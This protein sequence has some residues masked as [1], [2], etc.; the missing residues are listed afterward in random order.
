MPELCD[1]S[2]LRTAWPFLK[3]P[4]FPSMGRRSTQWCWPSCERK[5]GRHSSTWIPFCHRSWIE[6]RR[7]LVWV[8]V[9][10]SNSVFSNTVITA[11]TFLT[12]VCLYK[13]GLLI[14]MCEHSLGRSRVPCI[15]RHTMT[16]FFWLTLLFIW[17]CACNNKG[18]RAR[19]FFLCFDREIILYLINHGR[20]MEK[21]V[22]YTISC[23]L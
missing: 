10:Y 9:V 8:S 6:T 12:S 7:F 19:H 5:E 22:G 16:L 23:M 14:E 2:S 18:Y 1:C 21:R 20:N 11:R 13:T 17:L 3:Y 15:S 4:S